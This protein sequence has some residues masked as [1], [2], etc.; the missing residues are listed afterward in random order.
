MKSKLKELLDNYIDEYNEIKA[1]YEELIVKCQLYKE[2]I[3]YFDET[4]IDLANNKV[5]ISL[6]LNTIYNDDIYEREFYNLLYKLERG[7]YNNKNE[8]RSF[9]SMI[10]KDYS[11][12]AKEEDNLKTI[13]E[14]YNVDEE[15]LKKYNNEEIKPH[16]KIIIPY[17][18]DD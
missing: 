15:I 16:D 6:L 13:S 14:K 10:N 12:V 4:N 5:S 3:S 17:M 18:F 8:I 2:L 9:L 11:R 1:R 7:E